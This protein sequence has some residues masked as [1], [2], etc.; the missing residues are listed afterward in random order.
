VLTSLTARGR[1][2]IE[3]RRRKYEPRWQSALD[4]FSDEELL[5]SVR[6]LDAIRTMF[7]E[8]EPGESN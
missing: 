3:E 5:T 2:L 4:D 6:V 1:E 7:D 8:N